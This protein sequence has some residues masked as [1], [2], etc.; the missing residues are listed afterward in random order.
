M[1]LVAFVVAGLFHPV[2]YHFHFYYAAGLS[3]ALA[4][5]WESEHA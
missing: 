1:T 3:V 5:V 4:V 2:A